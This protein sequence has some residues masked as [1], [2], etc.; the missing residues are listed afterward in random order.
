[1]NAAELFN[2]E[3]RKA[4]VTGAGAVSAVCWQYHWRRPVVT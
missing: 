2:L 1:M 4:L 3:G